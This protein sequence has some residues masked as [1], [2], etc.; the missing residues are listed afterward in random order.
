MQVGAPRIVAWSKR[1]KVLG[2]GKRTDITTTE[3]LDIAKSAKPAATSIDAG[4]P[5]GLKAGR[6][7]S[8]TPDDTGKVPVS[9]ELVGLSADSISIARNDPR[10]G[11]VVV[12][13]P[14]AGF[15]IQP[16]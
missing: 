11:E 14:R 12:H 13:F 15:I 5:S 9:G 7:I 16:L 6:Q 8:I 2:N 3:A 10:V 1:M 4:D